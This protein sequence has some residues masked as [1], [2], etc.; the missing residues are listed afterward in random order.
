MLDERLAPMTPAS[1][2]RLLSA[3]RRSRLT[4]VFPVAVAM[5]AGCSETVTSTKLQ[6]GDLEPPQA[7][8][9]EPP[10]PYNRNT[11]VDDASFTDLSIAAPTV[12][13]KYLSRNPY[14]SRS[15]LETYQSNGLR[16]SEAL[17]RTARQYRINPLVLL[18]FA[19]I[20]EGLVGAT[21]YPFPPERVE[22]VFGCGCETTT[23]CDGRYAGFDRQIDCL[24]RQLRQSL[25]VVKVS[26]VTVSGFGQNRTT[27]TVDGVRVTPSNGATVAIYEAL[28]VEAFQ[29]AGG[30]WLFWN[31]WIK[32]T[33][34]Y[35]YA[36]PFEPS[37]EGGGYGDACRG[38]KQCAVPD[39]LCAEN[40][41]GGLCTTPCDGECPE[42]LGKPRGF[43][44]DFGGQG[45][46]CL[47]LCNPGAAKCR[48]GYKCT[49]IVR[50]GNP[51]ESEFTCYPE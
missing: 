31:L 1:P 47:A 40:Y 38:D 36:G 48:A 8:A 49:R 10:P 9:E 12:I 5:A 18:V 19:Q 20:R 45:G 22:Y 26:G 51:K 24:A 11:L 37:P 33:Q 46:Y 21:N 41:P 25:E 6:P 15:F 43:C 28:P 17:V 16:A 4:L 35:E 3:L 32:Y 44:A 13:Q 30:T 29:K 2:H 39:P 42:V 34:A 7:I 27:F 23:S 50:Y 14:E